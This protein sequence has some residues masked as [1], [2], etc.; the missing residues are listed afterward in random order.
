MFH[1][2]F[3]LHVHLNNI[4]SSKNT[5]YFILIKNHFPMKQ[6]LYIA[7]PNFIKSNPPLLTEFQKRGARN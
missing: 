1:L 4:F 6:K 5:Q 7:W 3:I 2:I